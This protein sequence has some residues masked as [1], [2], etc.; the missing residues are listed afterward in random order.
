M[1]SRHGCAFKTDSY[2]LH[3]RWYDSAYP[4]VYGVQERYNMVALLG[5]CRDGTMD[6][7]SSNLPAPMG[8]FG[9]R[10]LAPRTR[11]TEH[12][13][14]VGLS[15]R[16]ELRFLWYWWPSSL[17]LHCNMW[18]WPSLFRVFRGDRLFVMARLSAYASEDLIVY[19]VAG[20]MLCG[21]DNT[22]RLRFWWCFSS[23]SLEL[24]VKTLGLT[25]ITYICQPMTMC[26]VSLTCWR[27][28]FREKLS[29]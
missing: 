7:G 14:G 20:I 1:W 9:R 26:F 15:K 8:M 22:W 27:H 5:D 3:F 6:L 18:W 21:G 25:L 10:I 2:S 17:N 16:P 23:T 11:T 28:F 4:F 19:V 24:W 29:I 12:E 13:N